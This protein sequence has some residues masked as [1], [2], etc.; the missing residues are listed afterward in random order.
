MKRNC[1]V[2]PT[3]PLASTTSTNVCVLPTSPPLPYL[4]AVVISPIRSRHITNTQL[5]YH[6]YA[7]VSVHDVHDVHDVHAVSCCPEQQQQV[8]WAPVSFSL[9]KRHAESVPRNRPKKSSSQQ[10]RQDSR[11]RIRHQQQ[12]QQQQDPQQRLLFYLRVPT[13]YD[14]KYCTMM[15]WTDKSFCYWPW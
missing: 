11:S 13:T 9:Q 1:Y 6:L 10:Q 15:P 12:Q 3:Q 2:P 5:S 14:T 4:Y 7:A 8:C